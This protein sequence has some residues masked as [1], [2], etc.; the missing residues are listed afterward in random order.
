MKQFILPDL[1]DHTGM[2]RLSGKDYHYLAHVRRFKAGTLFTAL[3]PGGE[4]VQ[5]RVRSVEPD[6]LIGSCQVMETADFRESALPPILLFQGLPKPAK[7]D[8]IV[9]QAAEGGI[10]EIVPFVC[11]YSPVRLEENKTERWSRI[12]K[13]A[14]QQSGSKI[15]TAVRTPCTLDAL[16]SRWDDLKRRYAQAVGLFFHQDPLEP[17]GFHRCLAGS[18]EAVVLAVGPEGGFS[19]AEVTDFLRAGFKPLVLGTTV[20]RTETAALAAAA[21]VRIILLESESWMLKIP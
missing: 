2:I 3:L 17:G 19:P 6:C 7:M 5:V 16:L 9:R 4:P 15:A 11:E 21:A 13:E 12:I 10:A 14:R 1:P 20:L 8:L 18:P